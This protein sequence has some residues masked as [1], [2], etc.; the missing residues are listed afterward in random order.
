MV[1]RV[2][3]AAAAIQS[4][5]LFNRRVVEE[6]SSHLSLLTVTLMFQLLVFISV[7]WT[8]VSPFSLRHIHWWEANLF[9]PEAFWFHLLVRTYQLKF[10]IYFSDLSC[11]S[12]KTTL[13]MALNIIF[14][15]K[16]FGSF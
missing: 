8:P 14:H 10:W 7:I 1:D 6:M 16:P 2:P 9:N 13:I 3:A 4:A 5:S 15:L 11:L 12:R